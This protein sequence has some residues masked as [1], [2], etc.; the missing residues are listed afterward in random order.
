MNKRAARW[1][2]YSL[3]L[4]TPACD[5]CGKT[6]KPSTPFGV[7]SA[8]PS[9]STSA[10][11]VEAPDAGT[12]RFQAKKA[13][14]AP[15]GAK[16]W[17]LDGHQLEASPSRVFKLGL[18]A[19]F[20]GDGKTES[21]AWLVPE[22][23]S[24]SGEL[25]LYPVDG[26]PRKLAGLPGFVP[27]G[28]TCTQQAALTQTGPRSVTMD[29]TARCTA[30]LL[31]R[32]PVRALFTLAPLA[33]RPELV[34]LRVAT[35]ALGDAFELAMDSS[36]QD[37]DGRD[38]ARLTVRQLPSCRSAAPDASCNPDPDEREAMATLVWLDRAA[39][40]S[41]DTSE[42]AAS[43]KRLATWELGRSKRKQLAPGTF[44]TVRNVRRLMSTLCAEAGV[45]RILEEDGT[46]I[47]CAPLGDTLDQLLTAEVQAGL[48]SGNVQTA[49]A[50][51]D[52]DGWYVGAASEKA[53]AQ[54]VQR[55]LAAVS[56]TDIPRLTSVAVKLVPKTKKPRLSP[57]AFE[58]SGALLVQTKSGLVRLAS[59]ARTPESVDAEAGV[60]AW[61]LGVESESG[62]RLES[63][64][65]AC[66]RND[67]V[68]QFVDAAGKP[69]LR[70]RLP[71][72]AARPGSCTGGRAPELSL[73]PL[74]WKKGSLEIVVAGEH[75]GPLTNAAL[76]DERVLGTPNSPD[77]RF[78][79]LP[80]SLGL[81][82]MSKGKNELWR[83]AA[84]GDARRLSDCVVANDAASVACLEGN[85]VQIA[86]R[87]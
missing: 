78:L 60:V 83:G 2:A 65:Q 84:I 46:A 40:T 57:L 16:R 56:I 51:L 33:E 11:S 18:S 19:D 37:G 39:G 75:V 48:A 66:D 17:A 72:L 38:D 29:V 21:V 85:E 7:A 20:D 1:F 24:S 23:P 8:L 79:V 4:C 70:P 69:T 59:P 62:V 47:R 52:R 80:T 28:P 26:A 15:S 77:G 87:P 63:A 76:A 36:D 55:V 30:A 50:A 22:K 49:I 27:S 81:L 74:G 35:P 61:P 45:P 68:L 73:V 5:G 9:P 67:V 53:H 71:L 6:E 13:T 82:V 86:E 43:L 64:M 3:L 14:P 25:W 31:P 58:S 54:L 32:A 44:A 34:T 42:P 41:R 12:L 10:S